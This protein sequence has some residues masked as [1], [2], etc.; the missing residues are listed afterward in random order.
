MAAEREEIED[1]LE[2][3][4]EIEADDEDLEENEDAELT[5]DDLIRL[6]NLLLEKRREVVEKVERHLKEA[7][8]EAENL[9]DEAD[10][11]SRQSERA[12]FMRL[13]DK[14]SKLLRQIDYAL[15]KFQ[16]GI[17]GICEG[18]GDPI[19]LKRLELRPW[20]RYSLEHKEELERQ[21]GK[22]RRR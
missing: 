10:Q 2:L 7:I 14:E 4:D 21:R 17:Y 22:S 18:T 9:P 1:R 6:R 16:R 12:Y 3:S 11:A 13:A 5:Q 15:S 20:T 8:G 19:G